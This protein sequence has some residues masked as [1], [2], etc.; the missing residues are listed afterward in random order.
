MELRRLR[1]FVVLAEELHFGRAARRLHMA[2]PPLSQQ[3]RRLEDELGVQLFERTH[4]RVELTHSGLQFLHQAR[5]VLEQAERAVAVAQ[6]ADRGELGV[7][8]VGFTSSLPYSDLF[9]SLLRD[10]SRHRPEVRLHLRELSSR[11]QLSQLAEGRLD[12]GLVRPTQ[13]E[14]DDE[15]E[16][17]AIAADAFIVALPSQHRLARAPGVTLGQLRDDPFILYSRALGSGITEQILALCMAA[18]FSPRIA[19]EVLEM[20]TIV[21]LVAAGIGVGVVAEPLSRLRVPGVVFRPLTDVQAT[22]ELRLCARRG[23]RSP[24]AEQFIAAVLKSAGRARAGQSAPVGRS[25]A[26]TWVKRPGSAARQ[27]AAS[28][29]PSSPSKS[30]SGLRK[31]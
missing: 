26:Q 27:S 24:A 28:S 11:V 9:A 22:L 19:Q 18:G 6:R 15:L 8:E 7:V 1:Y 23:R 21:G 5:V 13:T 31:R 2:Q 14:H 25:A 30:S 4:H 29:E 10:F 17:W 3:I 16:S 12:V 20:P